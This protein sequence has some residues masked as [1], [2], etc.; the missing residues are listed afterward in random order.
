M[1]MKGGLIAVIIVAIVMYLADW[2]F[3]MAIMPE[4]EGM[5]EAMGDLMHTPE[6]MPSP[7]WW[8]LMEI[9]GAGL[10]A[11]VLLQRELST[12]TAA[13]YGAITM[14]AVTGILSV[15]WGMSLNFDYPAS[16]VAIESI[17]RIIL[18]S[19][20]GAVMVMTAKKFS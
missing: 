5:K 20:T 4:P 11:L 18:G 7:A 9:C 19:V 8:F 15:N 16:S 2:G 6:T 10:L 3:Y 17:Y 12:G 1:T 14:L 13:L